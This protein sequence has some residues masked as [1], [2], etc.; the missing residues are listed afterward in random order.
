MKAD[1][2]RPGARL[3]RLMTA[4]CRHAEA[5]LRRMPRAPAQ[6]VHALRLRMKKLRSLLCLIRGVIPQ[7][8]MN[9]LRRLI[10]QIKD[11][12]AGRRDLEVMQKLAET[13]RR[14]RSLP[15]LKLN[16]GTGQSATAGPARVLAGARRRI[17]LLRHEVAALRLKKLTPED[18]VAGYVR[19]QHGC[20]RRMKKCAAG[21]DAVQMHRWRKH[22]KHWYYLSLALG[23]LPQARSSVRPARELGHLLGQVNDLRLLG[24]HVSGG[25][26]AA[27]WRKA[28]A[29][30]LREKKSRVFAVAAKSLHLPRRRLR[31]VLT[32]Q[33]RGLAAA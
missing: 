6:A 31:K 23:R 2:Q 24:S 15:A 30:R 14:R 32:R 27:P 16:A 7:A 19:C 17:A 10:R 29:R 33:M 18:V 12:F 28:I 13:L 4:L 26:S 9:R 11:A 1:A 8:K 20:R 25:A 3:V 21:D 22:V 5:D